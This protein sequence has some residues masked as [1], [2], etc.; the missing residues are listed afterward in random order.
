[1]DYKGG[2]F[3]SLAWTFDAQKLEFFW[4]LKKKD[5]PR[6]RREEVK[7]RVSA[8]LSST[9]TLSSVSEEHFI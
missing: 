7:K 6:G 4:Q 8:A 5:G 1:L 9:L 2:A 3:V